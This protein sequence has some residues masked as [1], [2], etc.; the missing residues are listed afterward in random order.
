MRSKFRL[1]EIQPFFLNRIPPP[2]SYSPAYPRFLFSEKNH[3]DTTSPPSFSNSDTP[4]PPVYPQSARSLV[5]IIGSSTDLVSIPRVHDQHLEGWA[6]YWSPPQSGFQKPFA[7]I[8]QIVLDTSK[9][10]WPGESQMSHHGYFHLHR[11]RNRQMV[12]VI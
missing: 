4:E 5:A 8:R 10:A 7:L 1:V 12:T 11:W 3:S 6:R 9:T 2:T